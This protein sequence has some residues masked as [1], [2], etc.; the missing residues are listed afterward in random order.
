MAA[1][2]TAGACPECGTENAADHNY[3]KHCG[4]P[5]K[6]LAL[7]HDVGRGFAER[8]RDRCLSLLKADPD[9]AAAH[10]NLALAYYHLGQTGNAIR[11]FE[12][13]IECEDTYPGAHFQLSVC[14]YKR[15]AM[16]ECA[17]A[18]RRAIAQ[19]PASAPAHFRLALAL[20]HLGKLEEAEG[21]FSATLDADPE[22]VIACYHLGI[23]RERL[24]DVDGATACFERVVEANPHDASAHY[25]LGIAYKRKGLDAMAMSELAESLRLDPSDTAAAEELQELQR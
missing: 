14:H 10:Y 16:A 22:Y 5:L 21:A 17:A 6:S 25:H 8:T 9:N 20:F 24:N 15:G 19:N 7:E 12:R 13:T 3:C 1:P 18:A 4:A 23:V 2:A 11:A